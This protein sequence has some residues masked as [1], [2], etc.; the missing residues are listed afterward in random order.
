MYVKV[1]DGHVVDDGTDI[2]KPGD[3]VELD[4]K[5]GKRLI[6]RGIVRK[7]KAPELKPATVEEIRDAIS[8]LDTGD[9]KLW[10]QNSG[11]QLDALRSVLGGELSVT[12]ELR[13]EGWELHKAAQK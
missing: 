9:P 12:S 13:D 8:L 3:T 5:E 6:Q 7:G 11:P 4:A 10:T 2:H 1:N